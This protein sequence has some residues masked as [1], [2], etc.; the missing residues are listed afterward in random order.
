MKGFVVA[1]LAGLL[2]TTGC[3][4]FQ[5]TKADVDGRIVCNAEF[6]DQIERQA[7]RNQVT[8]TWINCPHATLRVI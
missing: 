5:Y 7:R 1:G 6:M 2:L 3:A 8:V 4:P